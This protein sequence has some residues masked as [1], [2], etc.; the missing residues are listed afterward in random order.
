LEN[1]GEEGFVNLFRGSKEKGVANMSLACVNG[2]ECTG[3][4]QCRE[5]EHHLIC[6][7]CNHEIF[8]GEYYYKLDD[9]N[10]CDSCMD[11]CR[12]FYTGED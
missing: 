5:S 2:G 7:W 8:Q 3:C 9:E 6:N 10:V 1:L 4:M 12:K 11:D